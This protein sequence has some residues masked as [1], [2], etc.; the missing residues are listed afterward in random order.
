MNGGRPSHRLARSVLRMHEEQD[1]DNDRGD[2]PSPR[3]HSKLERTRAM[4]QLAARTQGNQRR[5]QQVLS[6]LRVAENPVP[7]SSRQ[8]E[9]VVRNQEIPEQ[10]VPAPNNSTAHA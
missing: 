3:E 8:V 10:E 5:Q 1:T 6:L 9:S 4:Q 7:L 2:G